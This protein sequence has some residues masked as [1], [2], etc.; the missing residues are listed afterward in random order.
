MKKSIY[1]KCGCGKTFIPKFYRCK[2]GKILKQFIHGHNAN[3]ATNLEIG[4]TGEKHPSWRGGTCKHSKGYILR[5]KKD[6]PYRDVR[7]YVPEH[8]LVMEQHLGRYLTKD[9]DVH[10]INANKT[11]NRIENLELLSHGEHSRI[12]NS[13]SW[14]DDEYDF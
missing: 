10:H 11:D 14:K 4:L 6:H 3:V 1:C 12:T 7:G 8:R 13:K 5:W 2:D 9:E